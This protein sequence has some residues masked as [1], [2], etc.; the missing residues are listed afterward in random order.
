MSNQKLPLSVIAALKNVSRR[1]ALENFNCGKDTQLVKDHMKLYLC[2][3]TKGIVDFLI[4]YGEGNETLD[5]NK[6]IE[7][8]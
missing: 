3:D 5:G 1:L 4:A 7:R 2:Q 8:L 6:W